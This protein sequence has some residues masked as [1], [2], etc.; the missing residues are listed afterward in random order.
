MTV[1]QDDAPMREAICAAGADLHTLGLSPGTS[2]NISVRLSDGGYLVTPTGVALGSLHP[3]RLTRLDRDALH[4]NGDHPTKE[5]PLHL[6]VYG[7]RPD[8]GA[9]VHLHST[10]ATAVSCMDVLDPADC[11]PALTA[12]QILRI[13]RLPLLGY[14]APGSSGLGEAVRQAMATAHAVLLANHGLIAVGPGLAAAVAVAQEIEEAAKLFLLL[15][16]VPTRPLTRF[17]RDALD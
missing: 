17:Q 2:G 7:A 1:K 5:V 11:L 6:G 8:A 12:Y 16:G 13:G 14:F 15:R 10:H 9:V 4:V 3:G